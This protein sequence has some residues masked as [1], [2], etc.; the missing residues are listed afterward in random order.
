MTKT[1]DDTAIGDTI[2]VI[3]E[4]ALLV[5]GT[6]AMLQ[7]WKMLQCFGMFFKCFCSEPHLTQVRFAVKSDFDDNEVR[8][9]KCGY[10]AEMQHR[11]ATGRKPVFSYILVLPLH[12]PPEA[13]WIDVAV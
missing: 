2:G 3:I 4:E 9:S 12:R 10:T 13:V 6:V 5:P 1:H 11:S 7:V 8:N